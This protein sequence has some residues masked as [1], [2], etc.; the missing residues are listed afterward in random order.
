MSIGSAF[1]QGAQIVVIGAGAVGSVV[2]YRLAQ[3]G[4]T[5]TIVESRYPGAGTSGNTFAWLNAFSKEPRHYHRLNAG[6]I[7]EHQDLARELD[8]DWVHIGGGL[9]W[10]Y[11]DDESGTRKLRDRVRQLHQWGYR[12][13]ILTPE[14]AMR[15]L[16]P[17]LFIDPDRVEEVV[18][19][20]IEGWLNGVGLCHTAASSAIRR[21][22]AR[23]VRDEVA[24]FSTR[25]GII[26]GVTLASGE[27]LPADTVINAAGP[28]ADRIAGFAGIEL[29][30]TQQPGFLVV[31]EPAPI[32]LK[33]IVHS[34]EIFM[35]ADGGWRVL[36]QG[37]GFDAMA[38]HNVDLN[39]PFPWK[40]VENA[41]KI[42][43]TLRGIKPEGTRIGVRPMPKDGLP[44]IGFDSE[45]P[46]LYH[47]VMHSGITL[48]ATVGRLVTEDF[49]GAEPPELEPYRPERFG[50][51]STE[52]VQVTGE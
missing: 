26:D 1:L 18:Y 10:V 39:H 17:D 42:A 32:N 49:L 2:A 15:D 43:P 46:G 23:I 14:Q 44:I 8:G 3:T 28:T 29:P 13:E 9:T 22:G 40:A 7:R 34:P 47:T 33:T 12:I 38:E 35:H 5:V 45:V 11:H 30:I 6:S 41:T 19:A 16:E 25:Y 36:L 48:A 24:G 52:G 37:E 27:T 31:T 4:A 51:Q 21:Y 20:P 50:A